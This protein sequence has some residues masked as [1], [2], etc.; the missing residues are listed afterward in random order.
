MRTRVVTIVVVFLAAVLMIARV[1]SAQSAAIEG[2]VVDEQSAAVP[3]VTVTLSRT[4]T[5]FARQTVSDGQG[6]YRIPGVPVGVYDVSAA[7]TGFVTVAQRGTVVDVSSIVRVDFTLRIAP[8]AETVNVAA[9]SPL[10]QRASAAL[11]GV[12]DQRR[13][14]ELPLNGRQFANLAGTL[15][16]VGVGFHRDP[17]KS[18]QYMP[19]V[20]GGNGRNVNYVVDGGDNNDDTVGGPLQQFPLDAIEEFRFSI[21]TFSAELGR[22]SGGVMS[23]VTKS[24]TNRLAGSAFNLARHEH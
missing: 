20:G 16:G 22:A 24:G 9:D 19:Q 23:V 14:A 6:T 10:L 13:I 1:V 4:D 2:R 18:S 17:T 21:A 11:G 7:L 8:V 5:G 3:G 12:V 15:P